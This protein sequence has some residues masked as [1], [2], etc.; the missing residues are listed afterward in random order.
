M[1]AL[2][3]FSIVIIGLVTA[4]FSV[5]YLGSYEQYKRLIDDLPFSFI[6]RVIGVTTIGLIG[7][8]VL[9]MFNFLF[10]NFCIKKVDIIAL[11]Q[12]AYIGSFWIFSIAFL[13]CLIFFFG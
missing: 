2:N 12:L 7:L 3:I 11:K 1:K 10:E 5:F 6:S 4:F 13:G 9:I 8:L